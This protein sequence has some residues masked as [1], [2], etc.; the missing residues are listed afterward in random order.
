[1]ANRAAG[2]STHVERTGVHALARLV[3]GQGHAFREHFVHDRGIDGHIELFD[4]YGD[5]TGRFI[6]VQIKS[7]RSYFRRAD[8]NVATFYVADRHHAYWQK[9]QMPVILVLHD[10]ASSRL[11][12][13]HVC[14]ENIVRT[15][16]GWRIDVPFEND[17]STPL[18]FVMLDAISA[19][20]FDVRGRLRRPRSGQLHVYRQNP[21]PNAGTFGYPF[22]ATDEAQVSLLIISR[23]F[24]CYSSKNFL[25]PVEFSGEYVRAGFT[26]E[27]NTDFISSTIRSA[28]GA[29]YFELQLQPERHRSCFDI[30]VEPNNRHIV[31]STDEASTVL[32]EADQPNALPL[33][34]VTRLLLQLRAL[35]DPLIE[36][37]KSE[38][39]RQAGP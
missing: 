8:E 32:I 5:P 30:F 2:N 19:S 3:E 27:F 39:Y 9:H 23:E 7:G 16:K 34:Y 33:P 13:Q 4:R 12:W 11:I 26:F 37:T 29:S 10:P 28:F 18:S 17:L 31:I 15:A 22:C 24:L 20:Q 36:F 38:T 35:F 14:S 6:A 21:N 1:L 25:S